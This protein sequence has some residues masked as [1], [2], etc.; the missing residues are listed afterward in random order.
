MGAEVQGG[1]E[2]EHRS[3]A[4]AGAGGG[5]GVERDGAGASKARCRS[6]DSC[7][8]AGLLSLALTGPGSCLGCPAD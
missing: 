7:R 5:A 6:Q 3:G 1:S 4:G 2:L 8:A